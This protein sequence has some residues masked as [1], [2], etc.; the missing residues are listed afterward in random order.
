M[1][2]LVVVGLVFVLALMAL[3]R[4]WIGIML[5]NWISIMNPHRLGWGFAYSAPVAMIAG[6][7]TLLG[8]LFAKEKENP[9]KGAPVLWLFLF[10]AWMTI[11][12]RLGYDPA[13][14]YGLWDR[15]MKI[16]VMIFVALTLLSNRY[17]IYAFIWVTVGSLAFYGVKGGVFT[18]LSGGNFRVWGPDGSFIQGNNEL[19]LALIMTIPLMHFLQL[20]M[21][22]V[23]GRHLMTFAIVTCLAAAL[24]SHSRG[25]LV[26]ILGMG[27]FFWWRS[28][29]KVA[30]LM[31]ILFAALVMI[32]MM[33]EHWWSRMDTIQTY[34]E[35]ASA[36]GR[37]NAWIVG[38]EVAKNYFFGGGMSYQHQ[39]FFNMY[40]E[41]STHI[42]AA[43]SIYFQIL[44][45]HGFVGLFLYLM[46]WFSTYSTAGWLRKHGRAREETRWTADLGAMVQVGLV[47]YALGGAFLS[48]AYFD[49]P[50]NMMVMVVL[51]RVWVM[52]H[53]WERDPQQSFLA[54]AGVERFVPKRF[55][56]Q[57]ASAATRG[58][59]QSGELTRSRITG[60]GL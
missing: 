39:I 60:G 5:W 46:L 22:G 10:F 6:S 32:P 26:A 30:M 28:R 37:I 43:H 36:M 29:R 33:P 40:G 53:G 12:W 25:A 13:G 21:R 56:A 54:Y 38:W 16:F 31:L 2:D 4:P 7:A 1:R 44:G 51:A 55:R 3:T 57:A 42:L 50:Y 19:A 45:N 18:I 17:H 35:D 27:G 8:T 9:F 20:Q 47:G 11:S 15:S 34:E 23:W 52:R 48:L 59:T 14:D 58:V 49:L 41:Y 24:G